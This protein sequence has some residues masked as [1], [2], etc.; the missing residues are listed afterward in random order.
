M[1]QASRHVSNHHMVVHRTLHHLR[2]R[3]HHERRAVAL[4]I[5]MAV[6]ALLF[7]LWTLLFFSS[8]HSN[9]VAQ[10]TRQTAAASTGIQVVS[11]SGY[12]NQNQYQTAP[13]Q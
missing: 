3:P 7:L 5:A 13:I 1:G 4:I 8:L 11:P 6:V 10:R 9:Q 2:Q 12:S